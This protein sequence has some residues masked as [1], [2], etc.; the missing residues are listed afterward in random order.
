MAVVHS[1]TARPDVGFELTVV[2]LDPARSVLCAAG[3][4]DILA[5]RA[6]IDRLQH[7]QDAGKRFVCLDLSRVTF[8]DCSCLRVLETFHHSFLQLHGRLILTG[9]NL[10]VARILTLTGL[11][12]SLCLAPDDQDPFGVVEVAR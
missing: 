6:L 4:L 1:L 5:R 10:R 9:V 12:D 11:H 3:E 7:Q 8:M 2:D